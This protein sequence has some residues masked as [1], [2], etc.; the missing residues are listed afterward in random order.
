MSKNLKNFLKDL[1]L[2]LGGIIGMGFASGKEVHHFFC[3]N[4]AMCFVAIAVFVLLFTT[5]FALVSHFV[6]KNNIENYPTFNKKIFGEYKIPVQIILV[7]IYTINAS[8][9]LA[10]VD[11]IAKT[12]LGLNYPICSLVLSALS[13]IILIGGIRRVREVFGKLL[14]ALIILMTINL[15]VNFIN[16]DF[17]NLN[18]NLT[19]NS[20]NN[21]FMSLI[22]P[23][24]FW[25]SNFCLGLNGIIVSKSNR[26]KLNIFSS[27]L[28]IIFL[29]LGVV[30][31]T[32]YESNISMPFLDYAKNL[33]YAFFII[34]L[35]AIIFALF[36]SL[37]SSLNNIK[38]LT[39][40][41]TK[42]LIILI[43]IFC[44]IFAFLGFDFIVKYLYTFSGLLGVIYC[45]VVIIRII[46]LN[47]KDK[48]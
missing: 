10:G 13:F 11:N 29:I 39:N 1:F 9:M 30:V 6:A 43:L 20:I 41:R 44:Q 36:S 46:I 7:I 19:S 27:F 2:I 26:K 48:K 25:G 21:I 22:L 5:C 40:L 35:I 3:H 24:I 8:C 12:F 18:F 45:V 16:C 38:I 32:N 14:P 31:L 28:I 34:Y 15:S 4:N 17:L 33:S 47:K 23:I 42:F 37:L